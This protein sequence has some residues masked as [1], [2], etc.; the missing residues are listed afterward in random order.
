M[1]LFIGVV[2]KLSSRSSRAIHVAEY[3]VRASVHARPGILPT[4]YSIAA[5][6]FYHHPI[7][8][9]AS[10]IVATLHCILAFLPCSPAQG[11]W[12]LYTSLLAWAFFTYTLA[13]QVQYHGKRMAMTKV[14]LWGKAIA[15]VVEWL[16]VLIALAAPGVV[17]IGYAARI[18]FMVERMRNVRQAAGS[19]LRVFGRVVNV[20]TLLVVTVCFFGVVAF[21]LFAGIEGDYATP[22]GVHIHSCSATLDALPA[23]LD[24]AT[25]G[26]QAMGCSTYANDCRDYFGRMPDSIWRMAVLATTANFPNIMLPAL[27][28]TRWSVLFFGLYIVAC[29]YILINL[30][31]AVTFS[32]FSQLTRRQ[33]LHRF[34]LMFLNMDMAFDVLVA[35]QQFGSPS[36]AANVPITT[37]T[38]NS[39]PWEKVQSTAYAAG[40]QQRMAYVVSRRCVGRCCHIDEPHYAANAQRLSEAQLAQQTIPLS[41]W[42]AIMALARPDLPARFV[43]Q[44]YQAYC[45][46]PAAGMARK[47]FQRALLHS[48]NLHAVHQSTV[49]RKAQSSLERVSAARAASS[50]SQP[51]PVAAS[52]AAATAAVTA[53]SV[54]S[55]ASQLIKERSEASMLRSATAAC[56]PI[57]ARGNSTDEDETLH[58]LR[59]AAL[60]HHRQ[61]SALWQL[62]CVMP[63]RSCARSLCRASAA[64]TAY[65]DHDLGMQELVHTLR[66]LA[67][68]E[69][70]MLMVEPSRRATS[71]GNSV[72][73]SAAT[74]P[75]E[76]TLSY[77]IEARASRKLCPVQLSSAMWWRRFMWHPVVRMFFELVIAA[78]G[79]AVLVELL[80]PAGVKRE[81]L[82]P[83]QH[84]LLG[85]FVLELV[86]KIGAFGFQVMWGSSRIFRMELFI[87]VASIGSAIAGALSSGSLL[88]ISSIGFL[89]LIRT[90]RV[91]KYMPGFPEMVRAIRDTMPLLIRH[92]MLTVALW[93]MLAMLNHGMFAGRLHRSSAVQNSPY[94]QQQFW[95]LNFDTPLDAAIVVLHQ[96][97]VNN[98]PVI[99]DG[100]SAGYGSSW[101]RLW[102]GVMYMLQVLVVLNVVLAFLI[103]SF[104]TQRARRKALQAMSVSSNAAVSSQQALS[105]WWAAAE[106]QMPPDAQGLDTAAQPKQQ[107]AEPAQQHSA[108]IVTD[109]WR[110]ILDASDEDFSS[111]IIWKPITG[112]DVYCAMYAS[113]ILSHF[114]DMY[115]WHRRSS[116]A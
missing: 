34:D 65:H 95:A 106:A 1:I 20:L 23:R 14:W 78:T 18:F 105:Q 44:L 104:S 69:S 22:S 9:A 75:Y 86:L 76:S 48:T 46:N 51:N 97:V 66:Q 41:L 19:L 13:L 39:L 67:K 16:S 80:S 88:L 37:A 45:A 29:V 11:G 63:C 5:S 43:A 79:V 107:G 87:A 94:G 42:V 109:A 49:A 7:F 61:Q 114:E 93:Y 4:S 27:E 73:G 84:V 35:L 112:H 62:V 113:D 52:S 12:C 21:A 110:S 103:E 71:R 50:T 53:D 100:L 64:S 81:V 54:P 31:L 60:V 101:P 92:M 47:E 57:P 68:N 70:L 30:T 59:Q 17:T 90:L 33:V 102:F 91:L 10:A 85:L 111:W 25:A 82:E 36:P 2:P 74:A 6:D 77:S 72:V 58:E 108:S 32:A 116:V 89:R 24:N 28:C 40:M 8:R 96:L 38:A 98:W 15:L 56:Q 99:V 115:I 55:L 26:L 3:F 83:T